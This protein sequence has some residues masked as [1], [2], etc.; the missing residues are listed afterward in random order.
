MSK[1]ATAIAIPKL[2]ESLSLTKSEASVLLPVI[3]GGNMTAGAISLVLDASPATVATA[4][5]GLEEKGLIEKIEGIVP[6]YRALPPVI[7]MIDV[8]TSLFKEA[9]IAEGK[10]TGATEKSQKSIDGA[11]SKLTKATEAM[12][13]ELETAFDKYEANTVES[14]KTHIN[15]MTSLTSQVLQDYSQNIQTA[16]EKLNDTLESDLGEKLV[17][18]QKEL[19]ISQNQLLKESKKI[20]REF[21]KWLKTEKDSTALSIAELDKKAK[22]LVAASKS[23][24]TQALKASED[25]LVAGTQQLATALNSSALDSSNT[26]SEML[27]ALAETLKQKTRQLESGIG[28]TLAT[29]HSTL[30]ETYAQA[31]V[32]A[33]LHSENTRKKLDEVLSSTKIFSDN[34]AAWMDEV[35]SFM[36][37]AAQS[38]LAQLE[39]ISSSENAFIEFIRIA[40]SGYIE[41]LNVSLS[42]EYKQLRAI[43]RGLSTDTENFMNESKTSVVSL[44][45]NEVEAE[46]LRLKT[47]SEKLQIHL[48]KW[49]EKAIKNIDKKAASTIENITSVLDTEIEE[50]NS[51]A[52]NIA[53]RLKSSFAN[54]RSTTGTK[55][56]AVLSNLKRTTREYESSLE[57]ILAEVA[58]QHIDV[59]QKQVVEAKVLYDSLSTRLSTRLSEGV[60]ALGAHVTRAQKEIEA[61]IEDQ[62]SRIDRHAEEMSEEFHIRIED[63]TR[64]FLTL[65]QSLESTFNGLLSSQA[66]EARDLIASAHTEYK[67]ALKTEMGLLDEDS[68]KLQQEFASEIGMRVDRVVETTSTLKQTLDEF[69]A[70]K[71]NEIA[72]ST[73]NTING[74]EANL[75]ASQAALAELET[76]T[77]GQFVENIQ[78]V[79]K[80]F[81]S[82]IFGARDNISENLAAIRNESSDILLKN[83][84]G[85]RATVENYISEEKEA[86]HRV[87]SG[88]STKLDRIA[89]GNLK[90]SNEKIEGFQ[91]ALQ[92]TQTA[93]TDERGKA[94]SA[95]MKT[96]DDRKSEAVVAFD[97]ASV[98]VESAISNLSSSVE[99]L[100]TKLSNEVL[101]AENAMTKAAETSSLTLKEGNEEL[102]RQLEEVGGTFLNH[103]ESQLKA[104]IAAFDK[105]KENTLN[106]SIDSLAEF[107]EKLAAATENS[108]Q[109]ALE[110]C[111]GRLE[112][113]GTST[114]EKIAEFESAAKSSSQE[115][116]S[117]IEKVADQLSRFRESAFDQMQQS[118]NL[119]NQHAS[120]KFES[121]GVNLK[122][123]LSSL[124]YENSERSRGMVNSQTANIKETSELALTEISQSTAN[125]RKERSEA[126]TS[127][128]TSSQEALGKWAGT[129]K[130][131]ASKFAATIQGLLNGI[132]TSSADVI[133]TL[134]AIQAASK[135]L[136]ILPSENTWYLSGDAETCGHIQ[137]MAQRAN[138]SILISVNSL[139]C[140]DYKK[141]SKVKTPVRRILIVPQSDEPNPALDALKGWRIWET[142]LPM[143]L[144]VRDDEEIV[145]GGQS[146][147]D[148]PI[149]IV[150]RDKA[151]L[152]LYHDSLGPKLIQSSKK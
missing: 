60:S 91:N 14:V 83:S 73:E 111:R 101:H 24:I 144:A 112:S 106:S 65:T 107:P 52:E 84:A 77:V 119:S 23:V 47:A 132:K 152:Q 134:N 46:Q 44:L 17:S 19:D 18:L 42:E 127:S 139:D 63:I 48:E 20:S 125:L 22:Q 140:L 94:L 103:S 50:L 21:D 41:K 34:V 105:A 74:I 68:L 57:T 35:N 128:A 82:S 135:E 110:D 116:V 76:G 11:S 15:T 75:K 113:L 97:A 30:K 2:T 109:E 38:V 43:S 53:S 85:V 130:D 143:L 92:Q 28:Q 126:I 124:V 31:R 9:E 29:S 122:A 64:Q 123:A 59:I 39:Q 67:N 79:S 115:T 32:N 5:K 146:E 33:D 51:L 120:R 138:E 70:V 69:T 7:P 148:M 61:T 3:R 78:Q 45:Q 133:E 4:L 137:D 147:T 102:L 89:S 80:E 87:L 10:I 36:E 95:V 58:A 108:N 118:T 26:I 93:A 62:V 131:T 71:K 98:W 16:L 72:E 129:A 136:L 8:L 99:T 1:S 49:N 141:L 96:I 66:V 86:L 114:A 13:S 40:L 150:S 121:L 104:G 142:A 55:N 25:A 117:L 12:S 151:Y 149:C 145:I 6:L 56:D 37:T 81:S 88:A 100:G 54:V 27:T 90:K